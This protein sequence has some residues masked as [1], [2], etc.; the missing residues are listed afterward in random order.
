MILVAFTIGLTISTHA[1]TA[2][3][4]VVLITMD[5]YRWQEL[6]GGADSALVFNKRFVASV[7]TTANRFY[8]ATAM[9][10]RLQL[11]PFV[12]SYVSRNGVIIGNRWKKSLMQVA[13]AKHTSYP[14]YNE[15]LCG[16]PD[17]SR[18]YS[19]NKIYNPNLNILEIANRTS[20]YT[21]R[22][23]AFGSWDRFPFILNESRN[24][25]K[26]NAGWRKSLSTSPSATEKVLDQMQ[27]DNPKLWK[28]VRYDGYTYHYAVEAIKRQKPKF[29]YIAFGE[30][31][32]FG[33]YGQ[34]DEYL[35]A[36]HRTDDFIRRLW[37]LTQSDVFYRG[38]TTFII[39]CDHGRGY[40]RRNPKVWQN[41][42]YGTPNDE[43]TWLMAFGKDVPARGEVKGGMTYYNKQVAATVAHYLGIKFA[44]TRKDAGR[45]IIF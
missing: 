3:R 44:P 26:V 16:Y 39:T 21:G 8:R 29:I 35:W 6:F 42:G 11:M 19:N 15:L 43:Q 17:D 7:P 27:D 9:E 4:R 12:W 10:R 14:G 38:K 13:N 30:T 18:I 1:Q 25:L 32:N 23:L 45:A 34:Y 36:A 33:H 41:H 40:D 28:E 22:V 5:G 20:Q 2:D 31:D 37:E 24:H